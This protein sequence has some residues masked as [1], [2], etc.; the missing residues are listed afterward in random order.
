[1]PLRVLMLLLIGLFPAVAPAQ[2]VPAGQ[3][4]AL[5]DFIEADQF[6]QLKISPDG[7]HYAATVPLEDRTALVVIKRSDMSRTNQVLPESQQHVTGF[8]WAS[9]GQLVFSVSSKVGYFAEPVPTGY[10]YR[11]AAG[12]GQSERLGLERIALQDPLPGDPR[13]VLVRHYSGRSRDP[14]SLL[15]L[16]TGKIDVEYMKHTTLNG[17]T[18]IVDN[19]GEI[20]FADGFAHNEIKSRLQQRGEDGE[21]REIHSEKESGFPLYVAGFSADNRTAY[22]IVEQDSGPDALYAHDMATGQRRLVSRH[23]RVDLGRVLRSPIT[24]AVIAVEYLDGPPA[25]EVIE[26]DDP[27]VRE[28]QK[29]VR[30]FPGAYVT[31][32]SYT[33]DGNVGIYVASSDVN[34][35]DFYRVDHRTGEA[36]Y[37]VSRNL[38]LGPD[39]MSPMRTVNFKS[40][41]GLDLQAFITVPRSAAG[42]AVPLVVI[43]HGGPKGLFDTWG[44]DRG[45][46]MLAAHGYAVMQVN[47]RGSG[48]YGRAF[49]EAGNGEWGARMQDDLTDATQWAIREG[50]AAP[51]QVCLYGA[52]YGA[53]AALMGLAREPG[54]YACGIGNLGIYDLSRMYR[55]ERIYRDSKDYFDTALGDVD[56]D[57][58]SPVRLADRIKVPVLLGAGELDQTAPVGQTHSMN[59]ALKRAGVPVEMVV[60]NR[61]MH[62]YYKYEHRMDWAK[63]VLAHL[64]KTIGA[65]RVAPAA[66]N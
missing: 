24:G 30:A 63:R 58:I 42:K 9:S 66:A 21:W 54:L 18:Y 2:A 44:F 11:V 49:R 31:P 48:N 55:S 47:F 40:R 7:E 28:L 37:L 17:A 52:S 27:F 65:G 57:T 25:L 60:Y 34:S 1:M 46:Q 56:L 22:L 53:Y 32:T 38:A 13:H 6:L 23:K 5:K 16:E 36:T 61:E 3:A 10:L 50:L 14:I 62:G 19:A 43:P 29:V 35:G 12:G 51:G 39:R 4:I 15:D 59:D 20:R 41:D 33:L 45:T 26:A 64:D 8:D